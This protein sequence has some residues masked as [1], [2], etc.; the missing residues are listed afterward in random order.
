MIDRTDDILRHFPT[1]LRRWD[2]SI[3][4][5]WALSISPRTLLLRLERNG[6]DGN[7]EIACIEPEFIHRPTEWM[8]S[9]V[10]IERR[11]VGFL[12]KDEPAGLEAHAGHVEVAENRKPLNAFTF[13]ATSGETG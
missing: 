8:D 9:H 12:V 7:L 5:M 3:A 1:L 6:R 4:M 11:P 10:E 13:S 2:D